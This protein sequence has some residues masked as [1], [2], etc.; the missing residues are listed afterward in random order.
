MTSFPFFRKNQQHV[1]K[2]TFNFINPKHLPSGLSEVMEVIQ[3][4]HIIYPEPRAQSEFLSE[5][6]GKLKSLK[7]MF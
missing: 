2:K 3:Q 6:S 1:R 4:D 7:K 5:N